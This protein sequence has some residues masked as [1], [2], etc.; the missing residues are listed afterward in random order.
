VDYSASKI[1][2]NYERGIAIS[3]AQDMVLA[4]RVA[5]AVVSDLKDSEREYPIAAIEKITARIFEGIDR[6]RVECL[7]V[8]SEPSARPFARL[9]YLQLGLVD[10]DAHCDQVEH[11]SVEAGD[12][13]TPAIFWRKRYYRKTPIK[14][15]APLAAHL[16]LSAQKLNNAAIGGGLEMVLCDKAGLFRLDDNS[17]NALKK[18]SASWDKKIGAYLL[19]ISNGS[20]FPRHDPLTKLPSQVSRAAFGERGR[21]CNNQNVR[22]RQL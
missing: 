6:K 17:V 2:I 10:T 20:P 12:G 15:L 7:I 21:D 11:G 8:F 9:F 14:S 22:R 13:E 5:K 1:V 16:I 19:D 3:C 4:K 18:A